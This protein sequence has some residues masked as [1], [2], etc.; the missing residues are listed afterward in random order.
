MTARWPDPLPCG[1]QLDELIAQVAD[2]VDGDTAHQGDCEHCEYA[3]TTLHE[4]W[5]AVDEL[6]H[7]QVQAPSSID[8]VV[9][10]RVRRD[11]FVNEALHV[12]GGILPRL[13]RALLTYSGIARGDDA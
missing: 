5:E 2:D 1:A 3:L 10:R 11:L 9:L 6:A 13:S 12:F 4:L 7:E 8:R